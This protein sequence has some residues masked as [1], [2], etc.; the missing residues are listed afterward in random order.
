MLQRVCTPPC[1]R[2]E[3]ALKVCSQQLAAARLM[4]VTGLPEHGQGLA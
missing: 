4:P 3:R 1:F 2:K